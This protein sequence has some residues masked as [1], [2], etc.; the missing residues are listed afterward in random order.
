M[1][2]GRKIRGNVHLSKWS[3]TAREYQR[4]R[5]SSDKTIGGRI[6]HRQRAI[7]QIGDIGY[8]LPLVGSR[9]W[10]RNRNAVWLIEL[11]YVVGVDVLR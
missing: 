2:V 1:S 3:L 9:V 7:S 5:T 8:C 4:Q 11:E 6:N 10:N